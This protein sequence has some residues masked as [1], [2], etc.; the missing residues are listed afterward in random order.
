LA[1]NFSSVSK[2]TVLFDE[3]AGVNYLVIQTSTKF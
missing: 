3:R 2:K 1:F